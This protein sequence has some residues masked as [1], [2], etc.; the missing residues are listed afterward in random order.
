MSC[1]AVLRELETDIFFIFLPFF[2]GWE[3]R[4][5]DAND[6]I[7]ALGKTNEQQPTVY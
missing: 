2:P 4:T 7:R 6:L 5:D 1:A 3:S